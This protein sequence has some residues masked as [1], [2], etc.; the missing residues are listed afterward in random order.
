MMSVPISASE[1]CLNLINQ[2][3]LLL[4]LFG[5]RGERTGAGPVDNHA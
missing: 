1:L 3:P 2:V 5:Q 4:G